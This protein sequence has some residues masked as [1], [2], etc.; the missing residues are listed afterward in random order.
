MLI[1][2]LESIYIQQKM[3]AG[4]FNQVVFLQNIPLSWFDLKR[5]RKFLEPPKCTLFLFVN[6]LLKCLFSEFIYLILLSDVLS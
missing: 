6:P 1:L 5:I 3:P 2:N 4:I